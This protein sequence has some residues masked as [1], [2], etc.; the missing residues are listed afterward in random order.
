[1]TPIEFIASPGLQLPVLI[2]GA[3]AVV[4]PGTIVRLLEALPAFIYGLLTLA[5]LQQFPQ[6][7]GMASESH[8]WAPFARWALHAIPAVYIIVFII[9]L[10]IQVSRLQDRASWRVALLTSLALTPYLTGRL[11]AYLNHTA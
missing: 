7:S 1:M 6:V 10:L 5:V 8:T 2:A 3:A 11:I 9:G 4:F